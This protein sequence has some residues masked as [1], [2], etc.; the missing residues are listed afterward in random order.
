MENTFV[1]V[2]MNLLIKRIV[3]RWMPRFTRLKVKLNY[4]MNPGLP[5]VLGDLRALEQVFINLISNA[6]EAMSNQG[7]VLSIRIAP[8]QELSNRPQLEVMISDTGPGIP[9]EL[10]ERIFEPFVTGKSK[11][12]GLGLAITKRIISAHQGSI[13]VN[14]FPGG[15]M[16][17]I[18]L[19]IISEPT[20]M[21]NV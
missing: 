19:P 3:D 1:P 15:T 7:G 13:W 5:K 9:D 18:L 11:G 10:R 17:H 6:V 14:S 20:K 16:F 21:E 2:D 4:Q 12:T 8:N